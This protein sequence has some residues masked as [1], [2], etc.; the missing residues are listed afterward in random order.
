MKKIITL[1]LII[2][3]A[4]CYAKDLES[5]FTSFH[6]EKE[7]VTKHKVV[8]VSIAEVSENLVYITRNG[9]DLFIHYLNKNGIELWNDRIESDT[10]RLQLTVSRNGESIV[11]QSQLNKMPEYYENIVYNK[12]G[13]LLFRKT[14]HDI[15][16]LPS[17]DGLFF[18]EKI[19][20]F[21]NRETDLFIYDQRGNMISDIFEDKRVRTNPRVKFVLNDKVLLNHSQNQIG[22]F[23][24]VNGKLS[25]TW[26][27]SIN[28]A[29]ELYNY[30]HRAIFFSDDKIVLANP[31][32]PF[33]FNIINYSGE[34]IYREKN[35]YQYVCFLNENELLLGTPSSQKEVLK[36][37]NTRTLK[38]K[39]LK[40]DYSTLYNSG[41]LL[42]DAFLDGNHLFVNMQE[43]TGYSTYI[44]N[45]QTNTI[46]KTDSDVI[47]V[48]SSRNRF[49]IVDDEN[50]KIYLKRRHHED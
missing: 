7:I 27:Y 37:L 1:I 21:A 6:V 42:I 28:N 2:S 5:Y 23:T 46:D 20:I 11:I 29:N 19:G 31:S 33:E 48:Y 13:V 38:E 50:Y 26:E 35:T 12:A 4:Y 22:L 30:F 32:I 43:A 45:I 16:L 40:F 18:Y 24:F 41:G 36:I 49:V 44:I 34:E 17:P 25:K 39:V 9:N 8:A 14:L 47:R 10:Y 15:V 3:S